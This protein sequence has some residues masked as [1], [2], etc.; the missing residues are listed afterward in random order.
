M[1]LSMMGFGR[2]ISSM[3]T[4]LKNGQMGPFTREAITKVRS[5]ELGIL[6]GLIEVNIQE[7]FEIIAC[8]VMEFMCEMMEDDMMA[9]EKTIKWME[10]AF[11]HGQM[12]ENIRESTHMIKS[13]A[14]VYLSG[15][16]G[17]NMRGSEKMESNMVR[18]CILLQKMKRLR[19][20]G[21]KAKG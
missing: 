3:D 7:N 17:K 5:M 4:E 13:K 18:E 6:L 16:M 1:E 15:Q 8:M 20:S 9:I 14:M 2:M 21:E 11:L 19:T 10:T 12:E